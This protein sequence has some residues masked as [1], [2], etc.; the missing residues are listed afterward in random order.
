MHRARPDPNAA[1]TAPPES[2]GRRR[3]GR[4]RIPAA[5]RP[6]RIGAY[7]LALGLTACAPAPSRIGYPAEWVGSPNFNERRP[8]YVVLHHTSDGS[9][10]EALRTLTDPLREVSA[11][12]LVG[13]DGRI[14]Q[15]VDERHRAWHAGRSRWGADADLNSSSIGIELDNDGDEPFP[16]AQ[17]GAL[18]GLLADIKARYRLPRANFLGHADVA[19]GRKV[20]PSARFPWRVL[21]QQGFGLWC[22]PPYPSAP[23]DFDARVG[24][25]ALGYDLGNRDAAVHAFKLHFV[26]TDVSTTLTPSDRDLLYCLLQ[27]RARDEGAGAVTPKDPTGS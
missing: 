19:P 4:R 5:A 3:L 2:S 1:A 24:L 6:A 15:L 11:H 22:D 20:D 18:L 21:A 17:I 27:D 23:A 25:Q 12:Y 7:A 26:Q 10:D 14:Y 9:A 16:A 8:S 13:R